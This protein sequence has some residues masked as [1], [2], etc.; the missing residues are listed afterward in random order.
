MEWRGQAKVGQNRLL[1]GGAFWGGSAHRL[2]RERVGASAQGRASGLLRG[3]GYGAGCL[4]RM[5]GIRRIAGE[6]GLG[7]SLLMPLYGVWVKYSSGFLH[8]SSLPLIRCPRGVCW[9]WESSEVGATRWRACCR[10]L[11]PPPI[12]LGPAGPTIT[13]LLIYLG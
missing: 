4:Y 5:I 10:S 8:R 7:R 13:T 9:G 1:M 2:G 11:V 3:E 12:L 6:I